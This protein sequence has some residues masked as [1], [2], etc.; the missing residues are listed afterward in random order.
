MSYY[1]KFFKDIFSIKI[2]L[3][4]DSIT[5]LYSSL[6]SGFADC[7]Y[8]N[9]YIDYDIVRDHDHLVANLE[10]MLTINVTFKLRTILYQYLHLILLI[11]IN[12]YL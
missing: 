3:K 11:M 2:P 5:P 12:I 6:Q 4:E 9:E 10:D 8:C 1:N 7:Y